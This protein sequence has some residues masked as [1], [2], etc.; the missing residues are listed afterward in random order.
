VDQQQDSSTV[1]AALLMLAGAVGA[2]V[3]WLSKRDRVV[4]ELWAVLAALG[5]VLW[6]A[7]APLP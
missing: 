1:L 5:L 6:A 7:T 4:L 2:F 3:A